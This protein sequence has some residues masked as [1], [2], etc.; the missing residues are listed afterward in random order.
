MDVIEILTQLKEE[1]YIPDRASVIEIGAQQLSN[2]VL[3]ARALVARL[4]HLF[5][6]EYEPPLPSSKPTTLNQFGVEHLSPDAPLAADLCDGS[7]VHT[8][9]SISTAVQ[10]PSRWI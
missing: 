8:H 6:M 5:G 9:R 4:G 2:R 1:G 7:V 3:R 10:T